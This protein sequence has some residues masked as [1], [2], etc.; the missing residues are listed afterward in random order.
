MWFLVLLNLTP[1]PM[2]MQKREMSVPCRTALS[3]TNQ[4][5][6]FHL[7]PWSY[8]PEKNIKQ[9]VPKNNDNL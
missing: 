3:A 2:L 6:L 4:K 7:R 5:A 8:G 1:R 9:Y